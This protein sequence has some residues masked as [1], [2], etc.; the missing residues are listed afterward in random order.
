MGEFAQAPQ[1]H[2]VEKTVEVPDMRIHEVIET[3]VAQVHGHELACACHVFANHT[4]Q[5]AIAR[6]REDQLVALAAA[7]TRET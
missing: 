6:A 7:S 2:V 3:I 1:I 5:R 4:L